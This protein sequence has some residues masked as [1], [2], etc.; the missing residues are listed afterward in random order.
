MTLYLLQF[1]NYYNRTIKYYDSLTNYLQYVI[2][3]PLQNIAF[4]PNDGV[5]AQQIINWSNSIPDYILVVNDNN[6]IISRW[7]V[8]D[9]KRTRNGQFSLNLRRDLVADHLEQIK[10][11]PCFIEKAKLNDSDPMIYNSEDMTFNQIKTSETLL[12]DETGC[13]WIVG[14]YARTTGDESKTSLSGNVNIPNIK[15][16]VLLNGD[17]S[18]WEYYINSNLGQEY[19]FYGYPKE[20]WWIEIVT[21]LN[22]NSNPSAYLYG[23]TGDNSRYTKGTSYNASLN[24]FISGLNDNN[25]NKLLPYIDVDFIESN[26]YNYPIYDYSNPNTYYLH[27][28]QDTLKFLEFNGKVIQTIE[29][30]GSSKY[31]KVNITPITYGDILTST[32]YIYIESGNIYNSLA[33]SINL[34]NSENPSIAF[35]TQPTSN[36]FAFRS[37]LYE[38]KVE[39]EDINLSTI[40]PIT[41]TVNEARY[42]VNDA[43]YDIFAI[44][45]GNITINNTGGTTT[46][47]NTSET[48]AFDTV[49]SIANKYGSTF[50]YDLQLVPYCPVRSIIQEDG[51]LDLLNDTLLYSYIK[52]GD[53]VLGVILNASKSSFTFNIQNYININ[54][55]KV[56]HL[57]EKYRLCSPNYNGVFEFSPAL[58]G[59]MDYF[60]VDCTYIPYSPYIHINPNFRNLYGGD[61]NDSRG[62]VCGGDFSLPI[63]TDQWKNY[64][65]NNKNYQQI[66]DRQIQ[67][68]ELNNSVA[69][70]KDKI[71]AFTGSITGALGGAGGGALA[72]G[73]P[74][75]LIAGGIAGAGMGALGGALDVGFNEMLRNDALDLTKDNF[76]YSLGNIQALPDGLAK[77]T[78]Y[79]YNNKIFPFLEFYTCT[80]EE[81]QALN[82]KL[83]YNGMTVMR[84]GK[85]DDYIWEEPTYIKGKIIRL[86]NIQD[87]FHISNEIAS[88]INKGVF[89]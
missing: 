45:Y 39:L 55:P 31:Y 12:K 86:E 14:Y 52:Q 33:N 40:D 72:G 75:G 35:T 48:L 68:M 16:D 60:N 66:F 29:N 78:A 5:H 28:K 71:K 38:Y 62:L 82:N 36:S 7:F 22:N 51:S 46:Q 26:I 9:S 79:T 63:V 27:S 21:K 64:Q 47:I 70:T 23:K 88:E 59:G 42:S 83:Q 49:M 67:S 6:E 61:F 4:N 20:S 30:D 1:N 80:E 41:Y 24:P 50:L 34:F 17:I 74:I 32:S 73:G 53:E 43:P 25:Y 87:D 18:S 44:P 11:A 65:L 77:T 19:I 76:G 3:Q 56:Q 10:N 89:I 15:A 58:N 13:P 84:I 69:L 57:T 8:I 37:I 85:I 54:N 81:K 2:G